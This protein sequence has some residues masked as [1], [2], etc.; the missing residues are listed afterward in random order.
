MLLLPYI[1]HRTYNP[2]LPPCEPYIPDTIVG[3]AS[4]VLHPRPRGN[5]PSKSIS[6]NSAD[7]GLKGAGPDEEPALSHGFQGSTPSEMQKHVMRLR[8][9]ILQ[10]LDRDGTR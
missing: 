9:L 6:I 8:K 3:A 5:R 7:G 4:I 2:P 1:P 10:I